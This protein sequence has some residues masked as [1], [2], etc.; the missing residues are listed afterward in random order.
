MDNERKIWLMYQEM[1]EVENILAD[2]LGYPWYK[3]YGHAT[4]DHTVV[5]L[6]MEV[7]QKIKTLESFLRAS[8]RDGI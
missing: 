6:A 7:K 1:M 2:A 5:T 3:D 4:G 8:K